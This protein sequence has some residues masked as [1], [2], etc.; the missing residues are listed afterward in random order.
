MCQPIQRDL[1][2]SL[3]VICL[4]VYWIKFL[5]KGS[6]TY[7]KKN[8]MTKDTKFCHNK[9]SFVTTHP[10]CETNI[11]CVATR[12]CTDEATTLL[13]RHE[14]FIFLNFSRLPIFLLVCF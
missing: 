3:C 12:R 11:V 14:K 6:A 9:H 5:V 4:F 1:R 7:F 13:R 10:P 8:Y 2:F